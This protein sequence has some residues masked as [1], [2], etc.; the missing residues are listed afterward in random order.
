MWNVLRRIDGM[1][2]LTER[3]LGYLAD[4]GEGVSVSVRGGVGFS[5]S[6]NPYRMVPI[7]K[8]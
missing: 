4:R 7:S 2:F 1:G 5:Q 3:G 8:S 6:I